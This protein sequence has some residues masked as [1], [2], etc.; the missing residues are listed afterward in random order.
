MC[1]NIVNA[2]NNRILFQS[3]HLENATSKTPVPKGFVPISLKIKENTY[4]ND[5]VFATFGKKGLPSGHEKIFKECTTSISMNV[6][7]IGIERDWFHPGI[8]ALTQNM[9]KLGNVLIS[10]KGDDYDGFNENRF[11]DMSKCIFPCYPT[12]MVIARDISITFE[13]NDSSVVQDAYELIEKQALSNCGFLMFRNMLGNSTIQQSSSHVS[14]QNKSVIVRIDS[15]Q[16]IGYCLEATRAD[17]STPIE[18]INNGY[19]DNEITHKKIP[20]NTF[21]CSAPKATSTSANNATNISSISDFVMN[22]K[23]LLEQ[24]ISNKKK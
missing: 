11:S 13:F 7:K 19:K 10:P 1:S 9:I 18:S 22:Y 23:S 16:L 8:F 2:F 24:N 12:A 3:I 15:T 20:I 21:M 4:S 14:S 6:A 17:K 5:F